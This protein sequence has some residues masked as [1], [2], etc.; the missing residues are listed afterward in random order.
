[1]SQADALTLT[2]RL[3]RQNLRGADVGHLSRSTVSNVIA[4]AG[5]LRTQF[6]ALLEDDKIIHTYTRKD[7]R[8][9]FKLFRDIFGEM[10]QMRV[11]LNEIILDPSIAPKV[12]ELALDPSKTVVANIAVQDGK[13]GNTHGGWM[14][15]LSKLFSTPG[16]DRAPPTVGRSGTAR[17]PIRPPPRFVPKLG[18]AL[19][20]SATTVNVEFSG[21]GVGKSVTNTFSAQ[22]NPSA[23]STM[24]APA[25]SGSPGIMG[26]FAGAPQARSPDPWVVL[27]R[28]PRRVS[29]NLNTA[30]SSP[31][32]LAGPIPHRVMGNAAHRLSRNVDA[33]IDAKSSAQ[34]EEDEDAD[35]VAP[36]L[37]RTLRRRGLSDSSIHSTYKDSQGEESRSSTNRVG[38]REDTPQDGLWPDRGSV[39]QALSKR[40]QNFRMGSFVAP[41]PL[42]TSQVGTSPPGPSTIGQSRTKDTKARPSLSNLIPSLAWAAGERDV[43]AMAGPEPFF[44]GSPRDESDLSQ[45]TRRNGGTYGDYY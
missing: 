19:S 41:S 8:A 45:R 27:P 35:Y 37:E 15:P 21:S 10:G 2:N 13:G 40:V 42:S 33:V 11:T 7:L 12:S 38:S 20:A 4:E 26:I 17:T 30:D 29:S 18:P 32:Q 28:G 44:A 36:L 31:V 16:G 22:S 24:Q 14:A 34:D 43:D 6:R 9:L 23:S 25:P 3:K 5:A 1:M 39:L